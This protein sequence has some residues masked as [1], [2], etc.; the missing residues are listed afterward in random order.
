M[1]E[2]MQYQNALGQMNKVKIY[3]GKLGQ[4]KDL[5]GALKVDAK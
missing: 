2:N 5:A 4:S 3:V 1:C